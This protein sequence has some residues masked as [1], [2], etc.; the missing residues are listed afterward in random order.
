MDL[1]ELYRHRK[2]DEFIKQYL[3][4]IYELEEDEVKDLILLEKKSD[5]VEEGNY[6]IFKGGKIT[7]IQRRGKDKANIKTIPVN[8]LKLIASVTRLGWRYGDYLKGG[9]FL[10]KFDSTLS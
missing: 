2:Y 1:V 7:Y 6:I 5:I 8:S 3:K 4:T 9:F 10:D